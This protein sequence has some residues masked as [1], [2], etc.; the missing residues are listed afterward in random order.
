MLNGQ[1][2]EN[3][4]IAWR[5]IKGQLL[6]TILTILIIGLGIMSLVGMLTAIDVLKQSINEQFS[7]LGS[8]TFSIRNRGSSMRIGKGGAKPKKHP[9]ISYDEAIRFKEEFTYPAVVSVSANATPVGVLKYGSKKTNPNVPVIGGDENYLETA[10]FE[11]EYGRN[12]NMTEIQSGHNAVIIGDE[13]RKNF[14]D[15]QSGIGESI[16]IGSKQYTVV[17]TLKNKGSGM[18]MGN[19]RSA[20]IPLNNLRTNFK[21]EKTSFV[22]TVKCENADVL[23]TAVGEATGLFKVIREDKPGRETSFEIMKSD[24]LINELLGM[25]TYISLGSVAI[26]IIT[27][28]GALI[29]LLNI[30]LVSVT[31]RT[32]EIGVRK[33]IGATRQSIAFQFLVEAILIC[34]LGGAVGV[35][36]GILIGNLL[37]L[38]LGGAFIVPWN[39]IGV[40]VLVCLIVGVLS[41]FY[42]ALKAS[43]LDPV[44]SLRYE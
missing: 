5:S 24:S 3:I 31:E 18:G 15:D 10:G 7:F 41:G 2:R 36:M 25:T 42:P 6:R 33:A 28:L 22:I 19:D 43:K 30:M 32:R 13:I 39:W 35:F 17:G 1:I 8:N 26:A 27:L 20:I 44:E 11:I 16:W 14:F 12:F 21:N 38:I 4:I 9:Q 40:A 23:E 29:G 34:Q 37:T